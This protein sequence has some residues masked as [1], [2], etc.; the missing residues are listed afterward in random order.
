MDFIGPLRASH[1][2]RCWYIVVAKKYPTK[3]VEARALPDNS[4]LRTTSFIYEQII[5]QYSILIQLT[6]DKGGHF[7]NQ[8]VK[9]LTTELKK[10]HSLSSPYYPRENG[11]AEATNKILDSV[12]YKSYVIEQ[13]DWEER[14]PS[15]LWA[16]RTT[17]KVTTGQ[18]PF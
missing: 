16:Y 11:Q 15:I 9:L 6:S 18:T 14:L 13:V 8:V 12:I 1:V 5:T 7:V 17:Y 4:T 10:I 2:R 3:W